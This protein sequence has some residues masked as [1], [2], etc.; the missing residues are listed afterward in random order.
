[1]TVVPFASDTFSP[2]QPNVEPFPN[3]IVN[4]LPEGGP[5]LKYRLGPF[6]RSVRLVA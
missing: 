6:K 3:L 5:A 1:M 4:F 2:E